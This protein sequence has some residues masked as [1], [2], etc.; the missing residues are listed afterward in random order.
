MNSTTKPLFEE[1]LNIVFECF[2]K[3]QKGQPLL[4]VRCLKDYQLIY[5]ENDDLDRLLYDD[6]QVFSERASTR[7]SVRD[8]PT[9]SSNNPNRQS[10]TTATTTLSDLS[11]KSEILLPVIEETNESRTTKPKTIV[12]SSPHAIRARPIPIRTLPRTLPA[13]TSVKRE[14]L[15]PSVEEIETT[16]LTKSTGKTI[17]NERARKM[18]YFKSIYSSPSLI[19]PLGRR[20]PPPTKRSLSFNSI[21]SMQRAKRAYETPISLEKK[22]CKQRNIT[23]SIGKENRSIIGANDIEAIHR[24]VKTFDNRR[25]TRNTTSSVVSAPS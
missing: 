16:S 25:W 8:L 7:Y 17:E 10:I 11:T 6:N 1:T 18:R 2:D 13:D 22:R 14:T 21:L 23:V 15:L 5:D 4:P 19:R 9:R 12:P 24:S 3:H 20:H